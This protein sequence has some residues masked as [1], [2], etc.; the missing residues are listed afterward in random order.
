MITGGA[1]YHDLVNDLT[2]KS[3]KIELQQVPAQCPK[4][5]QGK[6]THTMQHCR[7]IHYCQEMCSLIGLIKAAF[8]CVRATLEEN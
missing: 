4:W 7:K 2:Q 6:S 3:P 8:N 5:D 1:F